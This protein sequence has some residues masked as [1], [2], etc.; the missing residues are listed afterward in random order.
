MRV[1]SALL[2]GAARDP[3][4]AAGAGRGRG[5][6]LRPGLPSVSFPLRTRPGSRSSGGLPLLNAALVLGIAVVDWMTPAGIVVGLLLGIPIVLSSFA[7]DSR[8][9]WG[10]F[11]LALA[12]FTVA[13][14]FGTPAFSPSH[15]WIANR[16]FAIATLPASAAVAL[17]LQRRRIEA[18]RARDEA[19][20]ARDLNALLMSLLAHDLR[21]PLVLAEQGFQYVERAVSRGQDP[22][23]VL[24]RDVQARLQRSLRAVEVVL[25][26]ARED[27]RPAAATP[28][29]PL[30]VA[31]AISREV[32]AFAAEAEG[33]GKR[34]VLRLEALGGATYRCN[35]GVLRQALTVV[36]DNAVRH[37][38]PGTIEVAASVEAEELVVRITDEGPGLST[39]APPSRTRVQGSASSW[40]ARSSPAPA[41]GSTSNAIPPPAPASGSACRSRRAEVAGS[42]CSPFLSVPPSGGSLPGRLSE[43]SPFALP[44]QP[45]PAIIPNSSSTSLTVGTH[46]ICSAPIGAWRGRSAAA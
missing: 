15:V 16:I 44:P 3:D 30:E 32:D 28:D 17:L 1:E 38:V 42:R 13:A 10:T 45:A 2:L 46:A 21:T 31:E 37:A 4:S 7:D 8:Q 41:A 34:F 33:G 22:D 23:R 27:L 9:V 19:V 12:A 25:S 43:R 6:I 40:R 18:E 5:G 29:A 35:H 11:L 20:S 26:I 14:I 36:L 24:L 39:P